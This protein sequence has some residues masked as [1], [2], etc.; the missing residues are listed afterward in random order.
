MCCCDHAAQNEEGK[1]Y[2][3]ARRPAANGEQSSRAAP[4]AELHA[5]A[6][7]DGTDC[8]SYTEWKHKACGTQTYVRS[9]L[10]EW[11]T[12]QASQCDKQELSTQS[13]PSSLG[14]D[15]AP[16]G[17]KSETG[18]VK[19]SPCQSSD[20]HLRQHAN[21]C[22]KPEQ[23]H[24]RQCKQRNA[25]DYSLWRW[26][27]LITCS[28]LIALRIR[29]EFATYLVFVADRR[30]HRSGLQESQETVSMPLIYKQKET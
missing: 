16:C 21:R 18:V 25:D 28:L 26:K 29:H 20:Q 10:Q 12:Y 24:A 7:H 13:L 5:E 2:D 9:V 14:D 22:F 1:R 8:C 15:A 4:T 19:S 27:L 11:E 17:G 23:C 30:L 6:K 3:H